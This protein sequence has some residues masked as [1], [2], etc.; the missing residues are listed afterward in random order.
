MKLAKSTKFLLNFV[1]ILLIVFV[2]KNLISIPKNLYSKTMPE[3]N[4]NQ[5]PPRPSSTQEEYDISKYRYLITTFDM[6][7]VHEDA[8][9]EYEKMGF[10]LN[11]IQI[12]AYGYGKN[13]QFPVF[14]VFERKK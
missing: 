10:R 2:L 4:V 8:I 7:G 1:L 13:V 9:K 14:A 3:L 12:V 11:S 6:G 5:A